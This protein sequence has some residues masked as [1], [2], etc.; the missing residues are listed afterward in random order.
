MDTISLT[1][2]AERVQAPQ[3]YVSGALMDMVL[4]TN[5]LG[6]EGEGVGWGGEGWGG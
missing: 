4:L 6:G 2:A 1:N 5:A 3:A